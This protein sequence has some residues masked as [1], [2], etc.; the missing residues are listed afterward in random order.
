V[1]T[2]RIAVPDESNHLKGTSH[3]NHLV[4]AVSRYWRCGDHHKSAN[5][6]IVR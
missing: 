2:N 5:D 4:V 3:A 1:P 6:R